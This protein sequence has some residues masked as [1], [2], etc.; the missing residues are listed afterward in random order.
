MQPGLDLYAQTFFGILTA[1]TGILVYLCLKAPNAPHF[2]SS[3]QD[4]LLRD[5]FKT[6]RV[7]QLLQIIPLAFI[8][9]VLWQA[10]F[11]ISL[12][13]RAPLSGFQIAPRPDPRFPL[14]PTLLTPN[15][16]SV[17]TLL[18]ICS[19]ASMRL[20][21]FS[22]LGKSFTFDL[23]VPKKLVKTG[24][25]AYVQHPSYTGGL[26]ALGGSVFWFVRC[27]GIMGTVFPVWMLQMQWLW[28]R[29]VPMTL[30][31]TLV[32]AGYVRILEE[33]AMLRKSFGKEWEEWHA[34]TAR[35]VPGVF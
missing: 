24:V 14:N 28:N 17:P 5:A 1:I 23:Q 15:V 8:A 32:V 16:I 35:L 33:E 20:R 26:V 13:E 6:D 29:L 10:I 2:D 18:L 25:Y 9:M 31:V 21:A 22:T 11:I 4:S 30:M 7:F 12:A 27:D 3:Q 19:G 34:K